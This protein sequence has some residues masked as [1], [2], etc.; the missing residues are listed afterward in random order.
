MSSS[1]GLKQWGALAFLSWTASLWLAACAQP[2]PLPRLDPTPPVERPAR[3]HTEVAATR[4][5]AAAERVLHDLLGKIFSDDENAFGGST[6]T[7][8]VL[9]NSTYSTSDGNQ[10]R[11]THLVIE[12]NGTRRH[13]PMEADG[14]VADFYHRVV[15]VETPDLTGSFRSPAYDIAITAGK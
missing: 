15:G 11:G 1:R 12:Q 13:V 6:W 7:V 4:I 3:V 14:D 8:G 2:R 9:T 5:S 10:R